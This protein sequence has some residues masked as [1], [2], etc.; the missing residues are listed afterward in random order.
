MR[1]ILHQFLTLDGVC[2]APGGPD[3]DPVGGFEHGGWQAPFRAPESGA[4]VVDWFDRAGAFLLGR[5]TYEIWSG[6]WPSVT[7]HPIADRI[8]ALPKY[9]VS[10]TLT[11]PGWHAAEVIDRDVVTHINALKGRP[12]DEL[13]VHGSS[14][15]AQTLIEHDLVDEYRLVT[16]PVH[17][18]AGKR[19]FR[20]STRAASLRPTNSTV[21]SNGVRFDTF[22]PAGDVRHA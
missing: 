11:E 10:T 5:R 22:E 2:Q 17:V 7:D 4:L 15:L 18:G 16:F 21:T 20:D 13:Q 9:V 1:L 8:N 12:G 3:E 6:S 14:D 19:L